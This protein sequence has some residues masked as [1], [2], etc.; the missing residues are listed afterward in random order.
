MSAYTLAGVWPFRR[1]PTDLISIS[2]PRLVELFA[3]GPPN[4]SGESVTE[5]TAM[6]LSGVYR[7][8][9]IISGTIASLPLRTLATN[10]AGQRERARS[11]LDD[12][13]PGIQTPFEWAE[14]ILWHLLLHSDCFLVHVYNGAGQLVGLNPVHPLAVAVEWDDDRPGG[15][16]F[17]VRL[18]HGEARA[19]QRE[20]D[21]ATLTHIMGPSLDGLRGVSLIRLARNSLGTGIAGERSAATTFR[22]GAQ[23]GALVTPEDDLDPDEAK[24]ISRDLNAAMTGTENAGSIRVINRKLKLSPWTMS[25]EDAQW[26][27]SRAFSIEEIGRWFGVPPHL[28]GQSEKSTSWGTGIE[29]QNR[30]LARHTLMPWT[31]RMEQRL[32]R[33]LPRTRVAE[34]DYSGYLQP[35]PEDEINLL[36]K[37]VDAGLLTLNEARRIRNLPPVAGGDVPRGVAA[38]TPEVAA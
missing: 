2:D 5:G 7:A 33:L 36:I 23:F 28:L 19:E 29:E 26:L 35:S 25:H 12:P 8:G 27:Q 10:R 14:T 4:Y 22:N 6:G 30:G 31:T 38:P 13:N 9:S 34:F 24:T 32:T 3:A 18:D 16:L 15:K 17:K 11:F 20:F 1:Q 37:Q 21:G